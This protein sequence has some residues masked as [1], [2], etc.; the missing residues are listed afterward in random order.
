MKL[1]TSRD[2]M[3]FSRNGCPVYRPYSIRGR[4]QWIVQRVAEK[5]WADAGS[6]LCTRLLRKVEKAT[7]RWSPVPTDFHGTF[8]IH[9]H[10]ETHLF[11]SFVPISQCSSC[12]N[13]GRKFAVAIRYG[14]RCVEACAVELPRD[15]NSSAI[16]R[17]NAVVVVWIK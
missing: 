3:S 4:T 7:S 11:V 16:V 5:E 13:C 17:D 8:I 12:Q 14:T 15:S 10:L 2:Y 1:A 9:A 6:P